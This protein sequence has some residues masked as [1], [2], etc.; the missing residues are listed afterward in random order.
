MTGPLLSQAR[1]EKR[2]GTVTNDHILYEYNLTGYICIF[3]TQSTGLASVA[4]R[5]LHSH[6][7]YP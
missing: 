4:L 6:T 1:K 2:R 3:I 7:E 5:I